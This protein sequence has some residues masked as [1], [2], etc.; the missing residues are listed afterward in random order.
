[1]KALLDRLR[2]ENIAFELDSSVANRSS[3]RVGGVAAIAVFPDSCARLV[4]AVD[5]IRECGIPF[6]VIGNASN[7]LFGF[8]RYEGALIFTGGISET[9]FDDKHP[10]LRVGCGKSLTGLAE[11]AARRSLSGLEFA[12]GIPGLVGGAVFMNAGAYG[13]QMSDVVRSTLAYDCEQKETVI[14]HEHGF[15]YRHS[16]YMDRPLICLEATLELTPDD[17]ETV[18]RRMRENMAARRDKQPLDTNNAGSYFKRPEGH[19]AGKLIEDCGLKGFAVGGARVSEKHA[20]F[21]VAENGT[22]WRDI[23]ALE[24]KIKETVSSRFG[25]TLEREVRLIK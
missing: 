5:A 19:F 7:L 2:Q 6:E 4:A 1:M 9:V 18:R 12:Y 22:D 16:V 15:S 11:L 17:G 24:E 8:D 21:I 14:L 23:L 10:L 13:G 3:F 25:V 20:G